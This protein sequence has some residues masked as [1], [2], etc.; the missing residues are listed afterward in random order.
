MYCKKC[1]KENEDT[2]IICTECGCSLADDMKEKPK[3]KLSVWSLVGMGIGAAIVIYGIIMIINPDVSSVWI[4]S[5]TF[6]ADFYTE[7]YR[8][9]SK[10]ADSN[11]RAAQA[12]VRGLGAVTMSIG[13]FMTV[14]FGKSAFEKEVK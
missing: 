2:A 6:G 10:V 5:Y 7:I 13:A 9:T 8:A 3:K 11:I 12:V 1:G 14:Y 4:K